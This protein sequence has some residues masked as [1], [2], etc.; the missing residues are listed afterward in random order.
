MRP[1]HCLASLFAVAALG[2]AAAGAA[3]A[4]QASRQAGT[5]QGRGPG[6]R[7]RPRG[8]EAA[9]RQGRGCRAVADPGPV[10]SD[11]GR[12]DRLR[13]QPTA[14]ICSAATSTTSTRKPTSRPR[15]ATRR[16][17]RRWPRSG[18]GDMIVFSPPNPKM[19]VTVFTDI[20]CGFCRT[21]P[22]PDRRPE[23]GGR[24]RPLP[25]VPA[26]R[27]RHRVLAQGRVRVVREGPSRRTDARQEGRGPEVEVLRRL[28]AQDAVH[29]G[30]GPRGRGHAGDLHADGRLHR[31]VH[32][33]RTS[34]VQSVQE[35]QKAANAAR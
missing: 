11:H 20:D 30:R 27:P 12:P 18:E 5:G 33:P 24:A 16:A 21:F 31:R 14:S 6:R 7:P 28:V 2:I 32:D 4:G 10:R 29:D 19:T 22:Q 25:D 34:C 3:A 26:H 8:R 23:Q 13:Q 17:P 15:G 1:A 9:R 35:T